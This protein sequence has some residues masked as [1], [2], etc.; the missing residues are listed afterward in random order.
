MTGFTLVV[1]RVETVADALPK[2]FDFE[3]DT[4]AQRVQQAECET[5]KDERYTP[6]LKCFCLNTLN[7]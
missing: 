3:V 5:E 4:Y 2:D 7:D 6:V 1:I